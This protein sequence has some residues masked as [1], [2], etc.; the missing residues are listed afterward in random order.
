MKQLPMFCQRMIT[1]ITGK[2]YK[3]QIQ[4]TIRTPESYLGISYLMSFSG[5]IIVG[6]SSL[7]LPLL[8]VGVVI[9]NL[10]T[11]CGLRT[12]S[13]TVNHY[14]VHG[15]FFSSEKKELRVYQENLAEL[16]SVFGFFQNF[17]D[18]KHEHLIHHDPKI[19]ATINDPDMIF[20][21]QLGFRPGM[22]KTDLWS[23]FW[24]N[25][26]GIEFH[27]KMLF[28]RTKSNMSGPTWRK[29][30]VTAYVIGVIG[31]TSVFPISM[32]LGWLLPVLLVYNVAA[33][34][35][36]TSEHYWLKET[37][38]NGRLCESVSIKDKL[39]RGKKLT[40]GRFSGEILILD[41]SS[42]YAYSKSLVRWFLRMA[43]IHVPLRLL[44]W[45]G[46]MP[47][48]DHH[49]DLAKKGDDWPNFIYTRERAISSLKNEDG[50]YTEIWGLK[51]AIN[52]VFDSLSSH[53]SINPSKDEL[54]S[55]QNGYLGM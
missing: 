26:F 45:N 11:V 15:D 10:L 39:A 4:K 12:L 5:P 20:L 37:D 50:R 47:A 9:G 42:L 8:P 53:P 31:L 51:N 32:I 30:V 19:V 44:A 16:N 54:A 41:K 24:K 7:Y 27:R 25:V 29:I 52:A 6:V 3:G 18:Y 2:P 21:W 1:H 48:H 22:S 55:T 34:C 36:F 17:E 38:N 33:L 28:A 49:H 13:T 35:Q 14:C 43:F 23:V 40:S 46:D